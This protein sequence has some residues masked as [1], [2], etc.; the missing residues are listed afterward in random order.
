MSHGVEEYSSLQENVC[1]PK[2]LHHLFLPATC[3]ELPFIHIY[4]SACFARFKNFY[5]LCRWKWDLIFVFFKLLTKFKIF[6]YVHWSCVCICEMP[7]DVLTISYWFVFFSLICS[8]SSYSLSTDPILVVSGRY[9]LPKYSLC[10][11]FLCGVFWWKEVLN[12]SIL[13]YQTFL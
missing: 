1:F 2:W 3:K 6:P 7:N 10:L 5:D 13:G 4:V 11:H 8:N 12:F 9:I